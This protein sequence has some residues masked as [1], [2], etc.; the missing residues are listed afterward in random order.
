LCDPETAPQVP[1]LHI[2]EDKQAESKA[3]LENPSGVW[4][5]LTVE[6]LISPEATRVVLMV[7]TPE[8][9]TMAP[10]YVDNASLAEILPSTDAP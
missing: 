4:Q 7:Q 1:C 5:L 2:R 10:V 9:A 8:L 3:C 6:R